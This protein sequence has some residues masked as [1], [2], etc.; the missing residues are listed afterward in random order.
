MTTKADK[1]DGLYEGFYKNGKLS[2]RWN[3]QEGKREGPYEEF[4]PDGSLRTRCN[5]KDG[6][7]IL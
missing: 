7:Q 3:Y 6:L 4:Y 1:R 2:Y 5:Y